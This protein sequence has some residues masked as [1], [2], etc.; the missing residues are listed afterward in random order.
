MRITRS[1]ADNMDANSQA[2]AILFD[3]AED[4]THQEF[5]DESDINKMLAKFGVM[6]HG[7]EPYFGP[8]DYGIDLQ[9]ALQT[10]ADAKRAHA[11]LDPALLAK[12]PTWVSM[13]EAIELGTY[14]TPQE[15]AERKAAAAKA[16]KDARLAEIR[17]AMHDSSAGQPTTE[18]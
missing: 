12:Y 16:A 6:G 4:K 13:V 8:V 1:Q 10:I 5:K 18:E 17:E 11:A 9:Q 2:S 14:E 3:P 7:T 15:E